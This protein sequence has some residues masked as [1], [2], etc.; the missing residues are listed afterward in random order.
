MKFSAALS[1]AIAPVALAKAV[2]NVYPV[3]R[4]PK[5]ADNNKGGP[6]PSRDVGGVGS[7]GGVGGVGSSQVVN[8]DA[9][10]LAEA[11]LVL[12]SLS[13]IVVIWVNGGGGVPTTTINAVST[14]TQTV[15]AGA[16]GVA[17][18]PA[19]T[20]VAAAGGGTGTTATGATA[21]AGGAGATHTVTV[22][23]PKGLAYEPSSIVANVGDMVIFTFL[24]QNHTVSQ[25]AFATPC[26]LLAGGMDS[27]FQPNANNSVNPPPQ[28]ALQVMV[29]TPLWFYCRQKGHCGKG[30][31]F[32]INPTAAKTQAMFQ[33]MAIAQNGTGTGSAIT[34]NG[35]GAAAGGAAA[36]GAA[37]GSG[38][39]TTVAS[40]TTTSAVA[41]ADS[42]TAT[43]GG[44]AAT[45]TAAAVGSS[46]T[47]LTT[48]TG[49][50]NADGS[51][52]CAVMCAAG[53]FPAVQ[54]QGVGAFGGFGGSL[55]STAVVA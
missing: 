29:D 4:D 21:V 40:G 44:T 14:V 19:E 48:G 3:R 43:L 33:Q 47:G 54:A 11:G 2:H 6:H 46:G 17:G 51:C 10:L 28:V 5:N 38:T 55:P 13:E 7:V 35:G 39:G 37:A 22:G 30:M 18:A 26:E 34:G 52:S 25:S 36:G 27:G 31:T 24:S 45:N 9:A 32:S 20:T 12:G 8:A 50:I 41:A 16:G 1:L 15:T 42:L 23:G 49:S 53:S